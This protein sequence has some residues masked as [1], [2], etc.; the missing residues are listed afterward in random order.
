MI[1]NDKEFQVTIERIAHFQQQLAHL[2]QV[3]T[4]P[5][6]YHAAASGYLAEIDRMQL[7][8]R[9]YLSLHPA[10]RVPALQHA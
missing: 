9:D 8:V 7:E 6:N 2:R 1:T 3:E 5:A 4:N 10:E